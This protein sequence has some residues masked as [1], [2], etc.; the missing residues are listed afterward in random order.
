M[1]TYTHRYAAGEYEIKASV[2]GKGI[3]PH[4]PVQKTVGTITVTGP[5][6]IPALSVEGSA[7]PGDFP[8][9]VEWPSSYISEIATIYR[10][11]APLTLSARIY[12]SILY[13]LVS[14]EGW[15]SFDYLPSAVSW[16][17]LAL[18]FGTLNPGTEGF[19]L[20][21]TPGVGCYGGDLDHAI[22]KFDVLPR[23][24]ALNGADDLLGTDI[25]LRKIVKS[26]EISLSPPEA[27]TISTDF[28]LS[29]GLEFVCPRTLVVNPINGSWTYDVS[30]RQLL[31]TDYP[32]G[33][34]NVNGG[35]P[36]LSLAIADDYLR[37][38]Y[39]TDYLQT[40][41]ITMRSNFDTTQIVG[42]MSPSVTVRQALSWA[43]D[44]TFN[45][46]T[47]NT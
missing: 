13:Q 3:N 14:F 33:V 22:I 36:A 20:T 1:P 43:V 39:A 16:G 21:I 15:S 38:P 31:W 27:F 9:A 7:V 2:L 6:P 5:R 32:S 44:Y 24:R 23:V 45:V 4:Y 12:G 37:I 18:G 29:F 26:Q 10:P 41:L 46:P 8:G 28:D 19:G 25:Q 42:G 35:S 30:G 47:W 17:N 34:V 40:S 11:Q